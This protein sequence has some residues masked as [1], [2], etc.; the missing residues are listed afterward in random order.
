MS[1]VTAITAG[2]AGSG[3]SGP[4]PVRARLDPQDPR[5][6]A[7]ARF[8]GFRRAVRA[9]VEPEPGDGGARAHRGFADR[10]EKGRPV[11][12]VDAREQAPPPQGV[13]RQAE[14]GGRRRARLQHVAVTVVP[15]DEVIDGLQDRAAFPRP[16]KR[17]SPSRAEKELRGPVA[18]GH[19]GE[20]RRRQ[21]G[22]PRRRVETDPG[23]TGDHR[24][25]GHR[26]RS[27]D[28]DRPTRPGQER[29]HRQQKNEQGRGAASRGGDGDDR[30]RE[31][32]RDHGL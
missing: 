14:E 8:A 17:R 7:P 12:D 31:R 22:R 32:R 19:D 3:G 15:G 21:P 5:C 10:P 16:G 26:D 11:A 27:R 9:C 18:D 25:A 13:R 20:G 24:D 4:D 6:A 2:A 28:G 1:R 30:G 29:L 23:E